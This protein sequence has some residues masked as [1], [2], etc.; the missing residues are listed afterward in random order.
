MDQPL[1]LKTVV[2]ATTGITK[3]EQPA[4]MESLILEHE[5]KCDS[6]WSDWVDAGNDRCTSWPP[7]SYLN[8]K[9]GGNIGQCVQKVSQN[10]TITLFVGTNT[11]V[12]DADG[13][14]EKPFQHIV[15]ALNYAAQAAASYNFATINIYLLN[16]EHIM[17]RNT[18]LFEFMSTTIDTASIQK[19]ITIQPAF[20]GETIGGHS[21][22]ARDIDWIDASRYLTVAYQLGNE[23]AFEVPT[24]LTIRNIIFDALDSSILNTEDCLFKGTRCCTLDG[25]SLRF[26]SGNSIKETNW[27]VVMDQTEYWLTT[28]GDSF[29]KFEKE[30][31]TDTNGN[32]SY[33]V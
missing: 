11:E 2:L 1:V 7:G 32:I 17:S 3:L 12:H 23:F 10:T 22:T 16:M 33:K 24:M 8:I 5:N 15:K 20:C 29:F 14:Y 19:S 31:T 28:T 25:T 18:E 4:M 9:L 26:H 30:K 13:S 6:T 21:F 27:T